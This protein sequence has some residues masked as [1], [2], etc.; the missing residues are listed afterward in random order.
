MVKAG[1]SLGEIPEVQEWT[2]DLDVV[3]LMNNSIEEIPPGMS[4][5]CPGLSTLI[6]RQNPLKSS[7]DWFFAHMHGLQTLNLS[8]TYVQNLPD[9]ISDLTNLRTLLLKFCNELESV[10]SLEKLKELRH[11]DLTG[12]SIEEV[13]Q[14]KLKVLP[15]KALHRLTHLQGLIAESYMCTNKRS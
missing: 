8:N 11:L 4:P 10:P 13:P 14:G 9:S 1:H 7:P 12:T 15:T 6:L 5:K 2:D 3:S